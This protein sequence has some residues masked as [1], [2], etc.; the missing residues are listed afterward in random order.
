M[1]GRFTLTYRKAEL[2]AA[3]LG[4]PVESLGEYRPRYNIA[5]GQWHWILR[6]EY[7]DRELLPARWG[8]VNHW[9][10][11]RNQ[12]YKQINARAETAHTRPAFRDAFKKRRCIVPADG[13]FEWAGP[14]GERQ[15]MW[16]HRPD[17]GLL[18]FAGLYESWQSIPGEWEPT[19]TIVTTDASATVAPV[20]HRMPVI[21]AED[22]A[23]NWLH[24]HQEDAEALRSLLV[25]AGPDLL[26]GT[27]AS[28]R[29]N[30]VKND[31]PE[32]LVG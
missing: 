7:E 8:L 32:V 24:P 12:G 11:D 28:M 30:S 4:V 19:F 31:D 25:P 1:C 3:E 9:A 15:P 23:D 22:L 2:L 5:P 21:L 14:K 16:F 6:M 26:I 13:F 27:P 18:L 10:K 17:G 20:H 29:V